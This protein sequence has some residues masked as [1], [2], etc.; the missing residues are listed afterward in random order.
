MDTTTNSSVYRKARKIY[1]EQSGKIKCSICGFHRGEN[2]TTKYYGTTRSW[3]GND[4]IRFPS[5]KLISKNKKQWHH[6]PKSYKVVRK[7][8]YNCDYYYSYFEIEF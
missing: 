6:K 3:T 1:L 7:S 2:D 4:R 5:W 8:D